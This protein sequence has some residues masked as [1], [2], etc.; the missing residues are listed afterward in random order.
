VGVVPTA[1]PDDVERAVAAAERGAATWRRTPAHE[2]MRIPLRAAELADERTAQ[3]AATLSAENG[4]T[5][6]EATT[7]AGRSG[8][9]I[10]LSAF[11]GTQ[12]YGDTL[13][14]DAN[15]G[16][17]LDKIGFTIRQSVVIVA[18]ITPF[19]YPALLVLHKIAPALAAGNAV[20]L[21]PARTTPLTALALAACF[22][23][24]GLPEG[25]LSVL[26]G[27]GGTLGD[28]LVADP[29]IRK[30]SFTGSTGIGERT[31]ARAGSR[32]CRWS[33]VR[34]APS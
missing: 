28:V 10:R 33:S 11:E 29:R 7:E 16:T 2:R 5:I 27:P 9:L 8:D 4:K 32:S 26:T 17:G 30:V 6:T 13:P 15:R 3:I 18:A 31:P 22:L 24:A 20:V 14:L 23:D 19:N 25:V 12:L 21:K 34:P 1:G